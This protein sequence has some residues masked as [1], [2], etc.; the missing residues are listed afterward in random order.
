MSTRSVLAAAAVTLGV[1]LAAT[2]PSSI[3]V[4]AQPTRDP[5]RSGVGERGEGF[6]IVFP[7]S[8]T[9]GCGFAELAEV[10]VGGIDWEFSD[11]RLVS[12]TVADIQ[13]TNLDTGTSYL[14]K[15]RYHRTITILPDGTELVEIDGR[16]WLGLAEG[17]VGPDGQVLGPGGAEYF[18]SGRQTFVY[19]PKRDAITSYSLTGEATDACEIL[20]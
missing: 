1:M 5:I 12:V 9:A 20:G 10:R 2:L 8:K 4:A 3:A 19:D 15:S 18:V 17:D 14:Q 11:G 16:F 13:I 7:K 6:S